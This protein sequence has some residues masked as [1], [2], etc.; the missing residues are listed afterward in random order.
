MDRSRRLNRTLI[1]LTAAALYALVDA[2]LPAARSTAERLSAAQPKMPTAAKYPDGPIVILGASYAEGWRPEIPP[3]RFVTKGVSGQQSFEMLARFD[4]D[5][6]AISPRAV[7][8]WGCINDVFRSPRE[9]LTQALVRTR[10]SYTAMVAKSRQA[11]IEPILATEITLR[12]RDTTWP[13]YIAWWAGTLLG[14]TSYQSFINGHVLEL[15][16]W[17]REY[18]R[19]EGLLLLDLQP[20]VSDAAHFRRREFAASDGSHVSPAGYEALTRHVAPIL[21][22]HFQRP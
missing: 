7:I 19:Q 6:T 11:G 2:A 16:R 15:N 8:I 17:L 18:A 12:R 4:R 9:T 10:E 1:G 3:L 5:V 13:E 22:G 14:R 20:A 21:S